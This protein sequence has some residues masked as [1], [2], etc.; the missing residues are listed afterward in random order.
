LDLIFLSKN[1]LPGTW[2]L[3]RNIFKL[4]KPNKK[5]MIEEKSL[6]DWGTRIGA[7]AQAE[8]VEKHQL[9]TLIASLESIRDDRECLLLTA[10][11]AK[12]QYMRDLL[13]NQTTAEVINALRELHKRGNRE[14]ARK[15]F[16][17]AKWVYEASEEKKREILRE[18]LLKEYEASEFKKVVSKEELLQIESVKKLEELLRKKRAE[19]ECKELIKKIREELLREMGVRSIEEFVGL[20][21]AGR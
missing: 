6:L 1:A 14:D 12:R 8:D 20:L 16:G 21:S 13:G 3:G 9:E 4:I 19:R 11:F 10:A 18:I 15:M 17:V 5:G 7:I 2:D